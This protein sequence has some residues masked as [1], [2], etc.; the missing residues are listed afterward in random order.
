[1]YIS[2]YNFKNTDFQAVDEKKENHQLQVEEQW[3]YR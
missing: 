3:P 2:P 1:M